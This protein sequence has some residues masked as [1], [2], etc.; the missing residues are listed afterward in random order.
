M[1]V[2]SFAEDELHCVLH[3]ELKEGSKGESGFTPLWA[4]RVKIHFQFLHGHEV[5]ANSD[6]TR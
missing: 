3:C 2:V 1:I 5:A 4:F 6:S